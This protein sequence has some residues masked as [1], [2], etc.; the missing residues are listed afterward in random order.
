[1]CFV[2]TGVLETPKFVDKAVALLSGVITCKLQ[3]KGT[4]GEACLFC[5][6]SGMGR[7]IC[8]LFS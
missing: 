3:E 5:L 2:F 4:I 6:S 8:D 1:M 7:K